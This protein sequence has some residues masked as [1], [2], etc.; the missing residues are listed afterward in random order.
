MNA[1]LRKVG[2]YFLDASDTTSTTY[3]LANQAYSDAILEIFAE[4]RFHF[5]TKKVTLHAA[6]TTTL[7][8]RPY[9]YQFQLPSDFN[10]LHDLEHPT[11]FYKIS[12]YAIEQDQVYLDEPSINL[13]YT[14]IPDLEL[15]AVSLPPFLNRIVVLHIAQAL[16][17]ELS[18]SEGRHELLF[19]QY[20]VALRRARVISARQ[21]ASQSSIDDSTSKILG[22]QRTY[23]TIQ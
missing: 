3:E 21:G 1:A 20:V 10:T 19:Q 7:T 15:S 16:S 6:N 11:Q 5:N 18:G 13:Y 22:T 12:D 17:I 2:S 23:G 14:F 9:Q 8:D 4:H